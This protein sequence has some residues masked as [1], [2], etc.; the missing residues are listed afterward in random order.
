MAKRKDDSSRSRAAI[1]RR[2]RAAG[3]ELERVVVMDLQ[4]ILEPELHQRMEE[5]RSRLV[6][7]KATAKKKAAEIRSEATKDLRALQKL[8]AIR[9]GEQGRGAHEPD[10]VSPTSWWLEIARKKDPNAVHDKLA[11]GQRDLD[12][13]AAA[14]KSGTWSRVAALHRRTGTPQIVV[15]LELADLVEA[16][17]DGLFAAAPWAWKLPV[18]IGYDQFL[19]LVKE[20]HA[21]KQ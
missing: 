8:S 15:A 9:R 4:A 16:A 7:P 14:G 13:A 2:N 20:E 1:G 19:K 5:A 10:V 3:K 12:A 17:G 21:R 6:I 18:V 11:Q